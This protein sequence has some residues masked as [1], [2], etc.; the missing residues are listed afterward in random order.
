MTGEFEGL[1]K[2]V[3][4]SVQKIIFF[5]S[6]VESSPLSV[7]KLPQNCN[8]LDTCAKIDMAESLKKCIQ[9]VKLGRLDP[10]CNVESESHTQARDIIV[11]YTFTFRVCHYIR[12][13]Y[14]IACQLH[15][16]SQSTNIETL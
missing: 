4:V 12:L 16:N 1:P 9:A 10:I 8:L 3:Y 2:S 15:S 13:G 6:L 7:L 5:T 11:S 14:L